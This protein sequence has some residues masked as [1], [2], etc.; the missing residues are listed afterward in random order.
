[1]INRGNG[2]WKWFD[3]FMKQRNNISWLI[4]WAFER[5]VGSRVGWFVFSINLSTL[6]F[7]LLLILWIPCLLAPGLTFLTVTNVL[8][9]KPRKIS[10]FPWYVKHGIVDDRR[11]EDVSSWEMDGSPAQP[12]FWRM[13]NRDLVWDFREAASITCF[14]RADRLE[15]E[16]LHVWTQRKIIY[17]SFK[18]FSTCCATVGRGNF[19]QLNRYLRV[20]SVSDMGDGF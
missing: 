3:H 13:K 8:R 15:R 2:L 19:S 14:R 11:L 10:I 7:S 20:C 9:E 5:E 18:G 1:M 6:S 16:Y 4:N 17:R 12:T